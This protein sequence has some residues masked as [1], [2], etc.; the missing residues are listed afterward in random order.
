MFVFLPVDIS[1]VLKVLFLHTVLLN[2]NN[3]QI[4]LFDLEIGTLTI[5]MWLNQCGPGSN[6]SKGILYTLQIS[7]SEAWTTDTA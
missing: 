3:L 2:T 5:T 6:A 4:D 7:W 1:F